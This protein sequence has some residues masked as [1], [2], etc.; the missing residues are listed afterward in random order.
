MLGGNLLANLAL[1]ALAIGARA[2][3][4]SRLVERIAFRRDAGDLVAA[5]QICFIHVGKTGG[6]TF[7][8]ALGLGNP[9]K[10]ARNVSAIRAG[11]W[12]EFHTDEK[13]WLSLEWEEKCDFFVTWVRNPI[14]RLVSAFEFAKDLLADHKPR[15]KRR[16]EAMRLLRDKFGANLSTIAEH[17]YD[18]DQARTE[19]FRL[20]SQLQHVSENTAFYFDYG[21]H[22]SGRILTKNGSRLESPEFRRK[23]IFVGSQ[24]CFGEDL[25]RFFRLFRASGHR[26]IASVHAT[27][28]GAHADMERRLSARALG[29]LR[30]FAE[31]DYEVLRRMANYS[32]IQCDALL[33]SLY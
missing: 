8:A 28:S 31:P 24:E 17:L 33:K 26:E 4:E 16:K 1:A 6:A 25:D 30:R 18:P 9:G 12:N 13:R 20:F 14:S 23:L 11:R 32:M 15:N 27:R 22:T 19:A 21:P 7:R 3:V 29:N 2:G 10:D 5:D